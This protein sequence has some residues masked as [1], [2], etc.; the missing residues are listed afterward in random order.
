MENKKKD[1]L[2]NKSIT[3]FFL[4]I[5][6]VLINFLIAIY[7]AR[8][9]G[10]EGFGVYAIILAWMNILGT[11]STLG[12]NQI[13]LREIP[14]NLS[15]NKGDIVERLRVFV[16][17]APLLSGILISFIF[18][19]SY[20]FLPQYFTG[21]T[22]FSAIICVFLILFRS[23]AYIQQSEMRGL[24]LL[25]YGQLP[26]L[27]FQPVIFIL[28][29][30]A[31]IYLVEI[32]I[33]FAITAYLLAL[34]IAIVLGKNKLYQKFPVKKWKINLSDKKYHNWLS[35]GGVFWV[36]NVG[37]IIIREIDTILLGVLV[38]PVEAGIFGV[39][40]RGI[41][42]LMFG[43]TTANM[44]FAPSIAIAFGQNNANK[45]QNVFSH[46]ARIS[47]IFSIPIVILLLF[48]GENFL[49]LF[50]GE[51]K[52]GYAALIIMALGEF[53][54]YILGPSLLTLNMCRNE[55]VSLRILILTLSLKIIISLILIPK[56]G[57]LGAAYSSS[58][59]LITQYSL[60]AIFIYK[61]RGIKPYFLGVVGA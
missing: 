44:V 22:T 28:I 16:V 14:I 58:L 43:S 55:Y 4:K 24:G 35:R 34:V 59:A 9:L 27:L 51:F 54:H 47:L 37:S 49:T 39:V 42:I 15:Q 32:D 57:L 52:A 31:G 1:I 11:A 26:D 13:A 45:L 33:H 25:I 40:R 48:W 17:Y 10:V 61:I 53:T 38:G 2:T 23:H 18:F 46:A 21:I 6:S 3:S 19:I 7:L 41:N 12:L 60:A 20:W 36:I 5:F 56:Y 8:I 30:S 50:G 29:L